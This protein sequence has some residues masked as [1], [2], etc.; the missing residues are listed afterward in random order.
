[1]S[2]IFDDGSLRAFVILALF[3]IT[4]IINVIEILWLNSIRR[5]YVGS[6]LTSVTRNNTD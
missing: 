1:M 6:P 4:P 3:V 5:P 2:D